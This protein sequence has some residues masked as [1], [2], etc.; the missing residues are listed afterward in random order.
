MAAAGEPPLGLDP[1]AERLLSTA[2]ATLE[3]MR[4]SAD[5]QVSEIVEGLA[6]TAAKT[7]RDEGLDED[8]ETIKAAEARLV[9]VLTNAGM[10]SATHEQG[11][12]VI[13]SFPTSH[14]ALDAASLSKFLDDICP[15][16]PFCK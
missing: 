10:R 11:I 5:P 9:Y 8:P 3:T 14:T 2:E 6:E 4:I 13:R 15:I 1:N 7:L 16:W 12:D